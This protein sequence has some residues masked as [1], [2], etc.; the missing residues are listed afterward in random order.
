MVLLHLADMRSYEDGGV[1]I[2]IPEDY[3]D[4]FGYSL[5]CAR[6]LDELGCNTEKGEEGS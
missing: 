6:A 5:I 1:Y 3:R 2:W 4:I